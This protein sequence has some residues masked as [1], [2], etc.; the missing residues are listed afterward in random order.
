[1]PIYRVPVTETRKV[2]TFHFVEAANTSEAYDKLVRREGCNEGF[3]RRTIRE[4]DGVDTSSGHYEPQG[5]LIS[6]DPENDS[7]KY[8]MI[9]E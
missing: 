7:A 8:L 5:T 3:V 2:K 1:M 4:Q 9:C 6:V